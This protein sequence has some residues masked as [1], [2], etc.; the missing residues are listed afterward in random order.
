MV[1]SSDSS[2]ENPG[3]DASKQNCDE[4]SKLLTIYEVSVGLLKK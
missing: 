4:V 1:S 3:E 2:D